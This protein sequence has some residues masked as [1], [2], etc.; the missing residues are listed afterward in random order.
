MELGAEFSEL[1]S[2]ILVQVYLSWPQM[3]CML[4][5]PHFWWKR[6][7]RLRAHTRWI[8]DMWQRECSDCFSFTIQ[9]GSLRLSNALTWELSQC[10]KGGEEEVGPGLCIPCTQTAWRGLCCTPERNMCTPQLP[11]TEQSLRLP[12]VCASLHCS[13]HR[14]VQM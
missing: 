1:K 12:L 3:R 7:N 6:V 5:S 9:S 11:E 10:P 2:L 8:Q 14:A 4:G 13:Q